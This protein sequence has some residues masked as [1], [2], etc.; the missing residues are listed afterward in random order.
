MLKGNS[1]MAT[2]GFEEYKKML[3]DDRQQRRIWEKNVDDK[4]NDIVIKVAKLE[5]KFN[6]QSAIWGAV[7]GMIPVILVLV[8]MALK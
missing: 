3:L 6:F 7:A 5:I 2:N 1:G 8:Y 4:L